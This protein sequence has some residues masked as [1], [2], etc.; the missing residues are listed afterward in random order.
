MAHHFQTQKIYSSTNNKNPSPKHKMKQTQTYL[1]FFTL[2]LI[3]NK[4]TI[5]YINLA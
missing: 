1:N 4:N 3:S 5:S 2:E